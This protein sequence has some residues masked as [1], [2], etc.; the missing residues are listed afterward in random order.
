MAESQGDASPEFLELGR[1]LSSPLFV[2]V[3]Q[4]APGAA[5]SEALNEAWLRFAEEA[6][7]RFPVSRL[8]MA[9]VVEVVAHAMQVFGDR[10]KAVRWLR[11]PI[12]SLGDRTPEEMLTVEG[13]FEK[14]HQVLGRIE[15]GVW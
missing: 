14:V 6:S 15:H 4:A 13:G 1:S 7:G 5:I 9:E 8:A 11:T 2:P 3:F 10:N 12:P